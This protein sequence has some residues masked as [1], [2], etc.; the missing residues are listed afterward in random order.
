MTEKSG[1]GWESG[2]WKSRK[3]CQEGSFPPEFR[4][5]V[6]VENFDTSRAGSEWECAAKCANI[7]IQPVY[8]SVYVASL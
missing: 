1:A 2:L 3:G 5:H 8:S 6:T 7:K 4:S